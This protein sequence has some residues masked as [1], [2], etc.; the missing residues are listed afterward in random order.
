MFPS[1][2]LAVTTRTHLTKKYLRG[3]RA[4]R[5]RNTVT[6]SQEKT[7]FFNSVKWMI[8]NVTKLAPVSPENTL[9]LDQLS[10]E[11]FDL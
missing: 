9:V 8:I 10:E 11:G 5:L 7:I 4:Y 1:L 3:R 6:C 2:S